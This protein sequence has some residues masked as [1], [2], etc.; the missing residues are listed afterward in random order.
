M[1]KDYRA[2]AWNA[3]GTKGEFRAFVFKRTG[4]PWIALRIQPRA[5]RNCKRDLEPGRAFHLGLIGKDGLSRVARL[6]TQ[7]VRCQGGPLPPPP[8]LAPYGSNATNFGVYAFV[9]GVTGRLVRPFVQF[10]ARGLLSAPLERGA[11]ALERV[12]IIQLYGLLNAG[13][14]A[15]NL[16]SESQQRS[17]LGGVM[18]SV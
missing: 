3:L 5:A 17:I 9:D 2:S 15:F 7:Q 12:C 8:V 14:R 18:D 10:G 11:A 13:K 4:I 16:P 6:T 1:R